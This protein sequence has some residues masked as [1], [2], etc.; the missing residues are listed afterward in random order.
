MTIVFVLTNM[1]KN[2]TFLM[3]IFL[4]IHQNVLEY[5][6]QIVSILYYVSFEIMMMMTLFNRKFLVDQIWQINDVSII[7]TY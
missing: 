2:L 4:S 7:S 5:Y 1:L 6:Y 3:N